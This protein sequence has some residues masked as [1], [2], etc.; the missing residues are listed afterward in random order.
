[1]PCLLPP[2]TGNSHICSAHT[3]VR[4][5]YMLVEYIPI[6]FMRKRALTWRRRLRTRRVIVASTTAVLTFYVCTLH[7]N[8][9]DVLDCRGRRRRCHRSA[10]FRL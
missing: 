10:A 3:N 1:M 8:T 5:E 7:R 9:I 4:V 2:L 6:I